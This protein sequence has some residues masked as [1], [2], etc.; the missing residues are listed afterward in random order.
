VCLRRREAWPDPVRCVYPPPRPPRPQEKTR[1]TSTIATTFKKQLTALEQTLMATTPHY[2]RCV[3]PNKLKKAN[4]FDAP[5]IL[6]QLLYRCASAAAAP[7]RVCAL[8]L[9]AL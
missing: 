1:S 4:L 6:D 3:K 2:V 8:L 7:C 9:P 5:M